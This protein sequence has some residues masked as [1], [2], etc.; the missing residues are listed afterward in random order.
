MPTLTAQTQLQQEIQVL[1]EDLALEVLD[2]VQF[3]KAKR[4]EEAFLWPQVEATRQYRHEH[5]DDVTTITVGE[6]LAITGQAESSD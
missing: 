1:T 4:A 5:P 6:W 2:F 3:L